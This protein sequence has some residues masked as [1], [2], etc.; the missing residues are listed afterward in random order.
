MYIQNEFQHMNFSHIS[1]LP[2]PCFFSVSTALSQAAAIKVV[3][4][5]FLTLL[6]SFCCLL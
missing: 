5:L 2:Q 4:S 3:F 6:H 1:P